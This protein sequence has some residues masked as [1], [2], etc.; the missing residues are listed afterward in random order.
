[1]SHT[2]PPSAAFVIGKTG[3]REWR[4]S[5]RS[6]QTINVMLLCEKMGGGGHFSMAAC[7]FPNS[8]L[9]IVEGKLLDTLSSYL[10]DARSDIGGE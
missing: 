5:A 3:D 9:P 7:A 8:T 4:I 10:D 2:F 1:M 6:D